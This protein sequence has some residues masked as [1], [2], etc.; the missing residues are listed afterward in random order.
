MRRL[1]SVISAGILLL[2]LVHA[3][4]GIYQLAGWMAGGKTILKYLTWIMMVLVVVHIFIGVK[5]TMDTIF[6]CRKS[7]IFYFRENCWFLIRRISGFTLIIMLL[8]HAFLF[9]GE[10]GEYFRLHLFEGFEL[11]GSIIFLVTLAIHL[12]SNIRP[13]LI[14]IGKGWLREYAGDIILIVSV[15]LLAAAAGFVIYYFRWNLIWRR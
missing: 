7:G 14:G 3:A 15:I 12:L 11:A 9:M 5:L 4:S 2:F 10:N 8:Y 1:N 6:A 13:L